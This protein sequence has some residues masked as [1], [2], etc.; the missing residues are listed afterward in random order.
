MKIGEYEVHP[1]ANL[2]PMMDEQRLASLEAS[3]REHGL[4]EPIVL[5][6]GKIL[7]GRNRM[8][9]CQRAGVSPR[10]VSWEETEPPAEYVWRLNAERRDLEPDQRLQI[11]LTRLE[12]SAS[13]RAERSRREDEANEARARA[14]ASQPRTEDGT[15]LARSR[16]TLPATRGEEEKRT[17]TALAK[18]A[19]VSPRTAQDAITLRKL[20]P[21]AAKKVEAGEARTHKVLREIRRNEKTAEI[22][23]LAAPTIDTLDARYPLILADPPWRYE[24]CET[25]NRAIENH[26]PTMELAELCAM[27]V[28]RMDSAICFMWAT[29]PKLDESLQVLGAWGFTYRTCAVWVKDKIGPGYYFRQ[30]HELLLVGVCGDIPTPSPTDRV[31]SVIQSPRTT[32]SKKPEVVYEI[33]ESMYPTLP[34]IE[35]FCRT[36]RQGWHH[37]GNECIAQ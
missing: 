17:R 30:R 11:C 3:I 12:S 15:K 2:F 26:Y 18:E 36:P 35:L 19:G 34:K 27:K 29:S 31:D 6:G 10:F 33:I 28:P 23:S 8:V 5:L 9:A 7:D 13:W 4:E 32:H 22:A 21:D 14:T 20:D 25:E 24:H 1:S 16:A 37:W